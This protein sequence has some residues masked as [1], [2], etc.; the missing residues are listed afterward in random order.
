MSDKY[1]IPFK[2][3]RTFVYIVFYGKKTFIRAGWASLH[4]HKN[5]T[6]ASFILKDSNVNVKGLII[7]KKE[8]KFISDK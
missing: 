7:C 3:Q 5:R 1:V 8:C 4:C 6:T 2:G